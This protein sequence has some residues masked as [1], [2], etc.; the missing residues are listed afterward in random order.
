MVWAEQ[1]HL[2]PM[3]WAKR[4]VSDL[5]DARLVTIPRAGHFHQE[6]RPQELARA[7]TE[8]LSI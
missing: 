5:P 2:L 7:V 4:L 6:E 1:D 3:K 8:F